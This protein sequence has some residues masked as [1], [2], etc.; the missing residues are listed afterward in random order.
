MLKIVF[1]VQR[2]PDLEVDEFRRYWTETHAPIA[3]MLP[4]LRKYVQHHA[5][6]GPD[7]SEPAFDGFAEMWWDDA[8]SMRE[9]LA[10][11]EGEAAQADVANF[12]DAGRMQILSVEQVTIV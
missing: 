8:E 3:A 12:V 6:P 5:V 10:S 11:P 2:R 1:L 9:A 4:G 7:G